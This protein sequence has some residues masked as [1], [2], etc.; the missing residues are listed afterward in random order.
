MKEIRGD[1]V[2][3]TTKEMVEYECDSSNR[4][5]EKEITAYCVD[6]LVFITK[7]KSYDVVESHLSEVIDT[8]TNSDMGKLGRSKYQ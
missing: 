6:L 2:V 4:Q 8:E 7:G 3:A 5:Q 1:I